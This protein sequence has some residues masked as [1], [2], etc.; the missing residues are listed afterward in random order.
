M[1]DTPANR[2]TSNRVVPPEARPRRVGSGVASGGV[3]TGGAALGG[4]F[5]GAGMREGRGGERKAYPVPQARLGPSG[6]ILKV[7]GRPL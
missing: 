5:E 1:A 6:R 7:P 4:F 3:G 2:A